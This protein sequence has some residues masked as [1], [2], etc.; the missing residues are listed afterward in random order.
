[1]LQSKGEQDMI[2]N[3]NCVNAD[4]V[5][6]KRNVINSDVKSRCKHFN[7]TDSDIVMPSPK[8]NIVNQFDDVG[9]RKRKLMTSV[10]KGRDHCCNRHFIVCARKGMRGLSIWSL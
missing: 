6:T 3:D 1:M 10:A 2:Q 4:V 7:I 9:K 8:R 5:K